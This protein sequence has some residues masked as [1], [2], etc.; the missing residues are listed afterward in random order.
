MTVGI[1]EAKIY[2]LRGYVWLFSCSV[3][4]EQFHAKRIGTMSQIQNHW[5]G[6]CGAGGMNS[7]KRGTWIKFLLFSFGFCVMLFLLYETG[8]LDIFFKEEDARLF[9]ES[10]GPLKFLGFIAIQAAQVV[11]APIPG[12]VTGII[13]GYFFGVFWGVL[14]STI[15]LTLGSCLAFALSRAYGRPLVERLVDSA[16]IKR[17][18]CLLECKG[19][20]LVFLLFLLP[21]FP[22]DYLCFILGLGHLTTLEFLALSSV[23]RLFGTVLLT[24]GGGFIRYHEY[25]KLSI[26]ACL[27]VVVSLSV[28]LLRDRIEGLLQSLKKS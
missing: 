13:G 9:L 26:L 18:E 2:G 24:L 6:T 22:K 4:L 16:V 27:A 10:L 8:R 12:E 5:P 7:K 15:G 1:N 11:L 23:G 17:F 14:L 19:N 21:G 25:G 20:C 3:G 28:F